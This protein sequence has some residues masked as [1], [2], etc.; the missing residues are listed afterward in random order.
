MLKR[1]PK[2]FFKAT[3]NEVEQIFN[4][5]IFHVGNEFALEMRLFSEG[6]PPQKLEKTGF[7]QVEIYD[8]NYPKYGIIWLISCALPVAARPRG[9]SARFHV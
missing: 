2:K 5:L 7:D 4:N 9:S 1:I 6:G 3:R 8:E